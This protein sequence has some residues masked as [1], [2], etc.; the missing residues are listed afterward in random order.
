MNRRTF[1]ISTTTVGI[2]ITV[3]CIGSKP[4]ANDH[5]VRTGEYVAAWNTG[6]LET[7]NSMTHPESPDDTLPITDS[8]VQAALSDDLNQITISASGATVEQDTDDLATVNAT[9]TVEGEGQGEVLFEWRDYDGEWLLWVT[10]T[11]VFYRATSR[12]GLGD[13]AP[14]ADIDFDYNADSGTV[15]VTHDGGD[16]ITENNTGELTIQHDGMKESWGDDLSPDGNTAVVTG[17]ISAGDTIGTISNIT[18]GDE[19][20][21]IWNSPDGESSTTLGDFQAP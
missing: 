5:V 1:L 16:S 18:S 11:P 6:D 20:T 2:G 15:T 12:G 17:S 21:L 14:N 7:V 8:D 19:I 13:P 3:G 9:I 4:M 10:E